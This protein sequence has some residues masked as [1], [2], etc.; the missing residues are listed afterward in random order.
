M[1]EAEMSLR[2]AIGFLKLGIINSHISVSL[3]GANVWV[4]HNNIFD[5]IAFLR[6]L[7]FHKEKDSTYFQG[8]YSLGDFQY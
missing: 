7:G 6:S 8:Q 2:L 5:V 4:Q 1:P 3:G